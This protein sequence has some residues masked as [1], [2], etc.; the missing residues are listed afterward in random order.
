MHQSLGLLDVRLGLK[1]DAL[2][3]IILRIVVESQEWVTATGPA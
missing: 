2:L 1:L 3:L